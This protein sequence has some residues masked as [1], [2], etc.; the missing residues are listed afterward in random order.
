MAKFLV[1]PKLGLTMTEGNIANWRKAEGDSVALGEIIFDVE[2][3]KITKEFESPG[4]GI[5]RKILVAEGTVEVLKRLPL[6]AR[7][8]KIF[9]HCWQRPKRPR[10]VLLLKLNPQHQNRTRSPQHHLVGAIINRPHRQPEEES[11]RRPG[12]KK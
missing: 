4:E 5:I 10:T 6:S 2:T 9:P 3:D 7:L 11:K 8:T 12:P 1:M